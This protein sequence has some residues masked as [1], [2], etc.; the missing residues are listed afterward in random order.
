M[1]EPASTTKTETAISST[2]I[3]SESEGFLTETEL[4]LLQKIEEDEN[5][6]ITNVSEQ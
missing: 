5:D 4:E 6:T 3:P 1:N 2:S